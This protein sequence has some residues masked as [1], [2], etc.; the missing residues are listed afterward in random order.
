MSTLADKEIRV[1]KLNLVGT[2]VGAS[3]ILAGVILYS[4]VY[5]GHPEKTTRLLWVDHTSDMARATFVCVIGLIL[6]WTS[7]SED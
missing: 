4:L 2:I 5:W 7:T 6:A 3:L 1:K